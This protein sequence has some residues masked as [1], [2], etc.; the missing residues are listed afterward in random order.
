MPNDQENAPESVAEEAIA[1][2]P[3]PTAED[4]PEVEA[5]AVTEEPEAPAVAES[6]VETEAE[7][8]VPP[9]VTTPEDSAPDDSRLKSPRP[10]TRRLKS[11]RLKSRLLKSHPRQPSPD[12]RPWSLPI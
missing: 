4:L 3:D 9:E 10:T 12:E 5:P 7:P 1:E 2:A 8:V 6:P 11:R